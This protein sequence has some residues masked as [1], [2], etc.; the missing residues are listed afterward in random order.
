ME[1]YVLLYGDKKPEDNICITNMFTNTKQINLSWNDSDYN[2]N[3][4]IIE[5]I[6]SKGIEQ[7]IFSGLEIGWDKL[8]RTIKS[9]HTNIKIKVICNTTDSL[10]YYN[11]ERENFFNLL[12]LSKENLIEDIAFLRKGQYELYNKLGYKCSYLMQNYTLSKKKTTNK[13]KVGNKLN[14]GIYPLNYSWDKNIFNQLCI[15]KMIENCIVNYNRLDE[16]M[17][18]FLTTMSIENK[19][20]TIKEIN[21]DNI[22]SKVIKNDINI[23]CSFTNYLNPMF[24]ISMEQGIPCIIGNTTDLFNDNDEIKQYIVTLAED[25]P[26]EN[27]KIVKKCI[28]NKEE[29]MTMYKKW[30]ENYNKRA[31]KNIQTF[32][33]K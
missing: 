32:I 14:I 13:E 15:A 29:I 5:E 22:I 6:I 8:I 31:N 18:D 2:N 10:L 1:K 17:E 24:F 20:D 16:R 9:K 25:N 19:E 11:Y 12:K 33:E 21:E 26:I 27:A 23:D 4:K 7:I 30:K 3:I 28:E